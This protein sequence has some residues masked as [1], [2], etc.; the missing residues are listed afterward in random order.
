LQKLTN[1]QKNG[2]VDH[3]L[4]RDT[5]FKRNGKRMKW[6]GK[7]AT[8]PTEREKLGPHWGGAECHNRQSATKCP[9]L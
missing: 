7:I 8:R 9:M 1:G 5:G 2:R 4:D 6:N 3:Q